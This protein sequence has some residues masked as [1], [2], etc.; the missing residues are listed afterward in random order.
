MKSTESKLSQGKVI[1]S[2]PP[3]RRD[4][5]GS[6]TS[7]TTS[8]SRPTSYSSWY[9]D[10]SLWSDKIDEIKE[11]YAHNSDFITSMRRDRSD[12]VTELSPH[13]IK[14]QYSKMKIP[15]LKKGGFLPPIPI[16]DEEQRSG[17]GSWSS[18]TT[19]SSKSVANGFFS[20]KQNQEQDKDSPNRRKVGFNLKPKRS[21]RLPQIPLKKDVNASKKPK[22]I[23]KKYDDVL[24]E[25]LPSPS[26][27]PFY[28]DG[29]VTTRWQVHL[30]RLRSPV[31]SA[32]R[33]PMSFQ[34]QNF[35]EKCSKEFETVASDIQ[36]DKTLALDT[37]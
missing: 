32:R 35:R 17:D 11:R 30:P 31:P 33:Q 34:R 16:H 3:A 10:D 36:S 22:S 15:K 1:R 12:N 8:R 20:T 23:L 18:N 6:E 19:G 13:Q 25:L 37:D 26:P 28:D 24:D 29:D 7:S 4:R 2:R 21:V 27:T 14:G 5:M 9:T